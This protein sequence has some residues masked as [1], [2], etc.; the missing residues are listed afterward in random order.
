MYSLYQSSIRNSI[1]SVP[2][3]S[4]H[5]IFLLLY[6]TFPSTVYQHNPQHSLLHFTVP[7][8]NLAVDTIVYALR[9]FFFFFFWGG[10]GGGE[11]SLEQL[12]CHADPNFHGI[13]EQLPIGT[14]EIIAC[15]ALV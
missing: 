5:D 4:M 7:I 9:T 15:F 2:V 6:I 3:H 1:E 10:G 14:H 11:H 12:T 8:R 13:N